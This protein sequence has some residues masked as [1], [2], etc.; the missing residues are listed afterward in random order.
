MDYVYE[1]YNWYHRAD[2]NYETKPDFHE[3]DEIITEQG[4][5]DTKTQIERFMQA[6][7]VLQTYKR[8]LTDGKE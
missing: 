6:G 3:D 8:E 7:V 1:H 2:K 5:M 4:Y